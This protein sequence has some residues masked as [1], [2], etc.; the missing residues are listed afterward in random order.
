MSFGIPFRYGKPKK[1]YAGQRTLFK[2]EAWQVLDLTAGY[3]GIW[4]TGKLKSLGNVLFLDIRKVVHPDIIASNE[5][6]PFKDNSFEWVVYDPPHFVTHS[7]SYYRTEFGRRFWGWKTK[8]Q[9]VQNIYRVN[10]EAARVAHRLILKW[11]VVPDGLPLDAVL[12]ILDK[13]VVERKSHRKSGSG[14]S[15]NVFWWVWLC[16][17]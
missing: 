5:H 14:H 16:K 11:T 12:K 7:D 13:W 4:R 1:P 9:L 17:K 10:S 8:S 3:R 15:D 6:L 2:T